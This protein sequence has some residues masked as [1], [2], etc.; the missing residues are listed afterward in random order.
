MNSK[1]ETPTYSLILSNEFQK[2]L[3]ELDKEIARRI[4]KKLDSVGVPGHL[5]NIEAL[6][7]RL[8]VL[9]RLRV[10]D[11]RLLIEIDFENRILIFM[12]VEHRNSVYEQKS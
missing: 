4:S 6:S 11:Y 10:G 9:H 5:P 2:S 3:K 7:G 12:D 1:P 8:K